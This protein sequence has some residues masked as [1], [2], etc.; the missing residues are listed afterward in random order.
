MGGVGNIL[1]WSATPSRWFWFEDV[2]NGS[3]YFFNY[4]RLF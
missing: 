4:F 1:Y 3:R 2:L